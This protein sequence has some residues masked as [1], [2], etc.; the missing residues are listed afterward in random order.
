MAELYIAA[1]SHCETNRQDATAEGLAS[2][3]SP[4]DLGS[5]RT[6]PM[7]GRREPGR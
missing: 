7:R 1:L 5:D 4:F 6:P 2:M 3:F